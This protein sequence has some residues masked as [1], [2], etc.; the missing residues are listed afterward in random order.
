MLREKA[1][2]DALTGILNRGAFDQLRSRLKMK[3]TPICLLLIDVDVFK[4]IN[5]TYGH[6]MGDRALKR[7]AE[8]L[9]DT[10]RASDFP[11]RIGGD[12]FAVIMT[13]VNEDSRESIAR[14]AE[15]MNH[16]L[17]KGENGLP[18]FSL[19]IGIAFSDRGFDDELYK[20]ADKA[21]YRVKEAGRCGYAFYAD[22]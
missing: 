15:E 13:E 2:K 22:E 18:K 6:E 12:E 14:K 19:S 21:L 9:E 5:D 17:L 3:L 4:S 10:F 11:A 16:I 8:L 20:K 1:E 7:V